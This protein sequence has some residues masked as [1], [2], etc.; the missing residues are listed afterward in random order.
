MFIIIA[1]RS[2]RC[3]TYSGIFHGR[4]TFWLTRAEGRFYPDFVAKLTGGRILLVKDKAD[5]LATATEARGK[6]PGL[7]ARTSRNGAQAITRR[8]F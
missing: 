8:R 7:R 6:R 1:S 4:S 3:G 5:R 2:T